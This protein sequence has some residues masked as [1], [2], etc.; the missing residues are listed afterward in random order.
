MNFEIFMKIAINEAIKSSSYEDVPV[1]ALIVINDHIISRAHNEVERK[2]DS[3]RHAE[4][5]AIQRA[6]RKVGYKHLLNATLVTTLEP[7]P[8]CAG[9]IL[10][11]RIPK[12]VFG[13]FD[14][15]AGSCGSI[16]NI[17]QNKNLNHWTE[18]IGGILQNECST[19]LKNFFIQLRN[20]KNVK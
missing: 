12:V 3:T 16:F 17:V 1:G 9:A 5:L 19:L 20:E 10:L 14:H 4:L 11:A 2:N 7:C 8:M 13:A 15:K 18:V 6:I